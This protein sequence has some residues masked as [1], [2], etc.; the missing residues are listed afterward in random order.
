MF[1]KSYSYKGRSLIYP[2]DYLYCASTVLEI[3]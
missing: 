1:L 2:T 3:N